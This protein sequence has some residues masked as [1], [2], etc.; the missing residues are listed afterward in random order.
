MIED[1]KKVE[2]KDLK[3]GNYLINLGLVREIEQNADYYIITIRIKNEKHVLKFMPG[4]QLLIMENVIVD[5][6]SE[7]LISVPMINLAKDMFKTKRIH[8]A[9]KVDLKPNKE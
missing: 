7:Y 2:A 6:Y 9:K 8:I 4:E 1:I 5:D 3:I